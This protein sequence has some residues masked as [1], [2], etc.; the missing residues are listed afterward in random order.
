MEKISE[1]FGFVLVLRNALE[2]LAS[3]ETTHSEI[4]FALRELAL[5]GR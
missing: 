4:S 5:T 3:Y 2:E 1:T